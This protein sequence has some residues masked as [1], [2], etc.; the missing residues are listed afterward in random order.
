MTRQPISAADYQ[1][2]CTFLREQ[3]GYELGG[4]KEYLVES[5]LQPIAAS[6]ELDSVGAVVERLRRSGEHAVREAVIEAMVTH[7]TTFFRTGRTFENFRNFIVPAVRAG[8]SAARQLRIWCA[9]CATGQEPYSVVMTLIDHF[10]DLWNWR[11]DILATDVSDRIL[12]H[13]RA[14]IYNQFEVQRGLPVQSLLKHF[15]QVGSQWQIADDIRR[16]VNFRKFNLLDPFIA[17]DGPYDVIFL[18]NVLIYFD[19]ASKGS[20]FS[21]LRRTLAPDGYLVLGESETVLGLTDEFR[22]TSE[23][24]GVFRPID[25]RR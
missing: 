18:C 2:L 1:F 8:R 10:A 21:K 20:I 24:A 16:R 15:R 14:G 22:M 23:A 9:G 6:L 4:G 13:A 12:E 7:E 17:I 11:I 19:P 25:D 5:R 3:I